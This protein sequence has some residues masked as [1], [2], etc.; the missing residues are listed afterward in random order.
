MTPSGLARVAAA[1]GAGEE[2]VRGEADD[3][4]DREHSAGKM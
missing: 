1:L 2:G 3:A 4:L